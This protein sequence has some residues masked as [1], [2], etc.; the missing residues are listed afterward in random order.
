[1]KHIITIMALVMFMLTPL[2]AEETKNIMKNKQHRIFIVSSYHREYLWS[3]DTNKGVC[4]GLLELGFFDNKDQADMFTKN[5]YIKTSSA[6]VKKVWMDTKRKNTR[7]E[8]AVTINRVARE[9]ENFVPDL[10]LLGDDNAANYI[11]N[12][13][14]DTDIPV[15]FWGINGL[16]LKYGLLDLLKHPGHNVT[17]VYQAGYLKECL[18]FLKKLVPNIKNFAI[19]SDDSPTGRSKAKTL[20]K[21]S[22]LGKLPIK[23]EESIITNSMSKWKTKALELQKKVDAFF[24]LNH[25][26]LKDDSG[27]S[28]DQLEIGAWYLRNIKIPE[29]SHEKQFVE[30]GMLCVCDDSGY[31]QGY[32][33]VKI[34]DRI[35]NKGE[36]PESIEVKAP[37]R[38]PFIVN[39][40]RAKQFGIIITQEMGVEMI[41]EKAL[42]LE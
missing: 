33:A 31:N 14:I 39:Q 18:I 38:G 34:A 7:N 23:L 37:L 32:V 4:A 19:L 41:I 22:R 10:I 11:G 40:L 27:N 42:A 29:C 30:E 20:I 8:I 17:G 24:V 9:I 28:V 5:D 1:M 13:F 25:N 26:S 2:S 3:Q 21:L 6:V 15:V 35:L 12:L 36:H 16:P